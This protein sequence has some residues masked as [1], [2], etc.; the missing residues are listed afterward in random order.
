[1]SNLIFSIVVPIFNVA[2]TIHTTISYLKELDFEDYEVILINDGSTDE[3]KEVVQKLI[4]NKKNFKLFN[5]T[6]GGPGAARNLGI[7]KSVGEYIL[8]F[9]SDDFPA[10]SIL[11]KYK[12]ILDND[13][14]IDLIISSFSFTTK[15]NNQIVSTKE[16]LV[17]KK[18]Y[19]DRNKF[20]ND[21][22]SLM[23]RQLMYVVWNKCYRRDL[24]V[25][26]EVTF[27]NYRSCEDRIFNLK[28]YKCCEHVWLDTEIEYFY[29]YDGGQG[30]TTQ[31]FPDK[32]KSFKEFYDL[33]NMVTENNAK[34]GFAALYLKGIVS[35]V[36]SIL[37]T[38]KLSKK[39]KIKEI[40]LI[41]SDESVMEAKEIALTDT[42]IKIMTK[43]IFNAHSIIFIKCVKMINLIEINSPKLMS[44]FKR[45]Y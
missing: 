32:F 44:H 18:Y 8:F 29:Q 6:N 43:A 7:K 2:R 10:K 20:L 9:D 39:Q 33:A 45:T 37:N 14:K 23:N 35:T 16:Y 41:L 31:Y 15:V 24:I 5:A 40:N 27:P 22:Y 12:K 38:S 28:Y 25:E 4:T 34:A 3:T 17:P 19:Q 30:I 21:I 36:M 13:P 11:K 26:N 1:M 42:K